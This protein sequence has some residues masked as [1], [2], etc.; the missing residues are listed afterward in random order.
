MLLHSNVLLLQHRRRR[1]A[2]IPPVIQRCALAGIR[3]NISPHVV[4]SA[5]LHAAP[6]AWPVIRQ[7]GRPPASSRVW[8]N[9]IP[10]V[11]AGV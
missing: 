3:P 4:R 2:P 8:A 6:P 10:P 7:N 9:I 5:S 11:R 1:V